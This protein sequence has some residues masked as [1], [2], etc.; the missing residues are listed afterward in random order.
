[1]PTEYSNSEIEDQIKKL[2]F[3]TQRSDVIKEIVS[4]SP[5]TLVRW[6]NFIFLSIL[7]L[8]V[9]TCWLIKYPDTIQT[10]AK[11]TPLNAISSENNHYFA[12]III[13]QSNFSKVKIDQQV[14]LR[15]DSYPF[16]EY[17][18]IV[19][20]I[21]FINRIPNEDA[22]IAEVFLV[23]GLKTTSGKPI[24]YQDGLV[25]PAEILTE[26]KRLLE[27]LYHNFSRQTKSNK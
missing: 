25:V 11:L 9:L 24:R 2:N 12:E 7:F 13:H 22:Y 8:I 15:F 5:G 17:G 26:D 20:K 10:S 27:R 21:K 18:F 6:G 14:L 3:V 23:N 4:D 16:Q 19:G 1:M